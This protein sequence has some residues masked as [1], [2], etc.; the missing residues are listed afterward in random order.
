MLL[1][2]VAG[3]ASPLDVK[4]NQDS[5]SLPGRRIGYVIDDVGRAI[6]LPDPDDVIT[7]RF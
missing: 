6:Q 1:S 2:N 5:Q 3:T 4:P 7:L